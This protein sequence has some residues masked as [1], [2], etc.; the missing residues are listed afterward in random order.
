M[1]KKFLGPKEGTYLGNELTQY[2]AGVEHVTS[3]VNKQAL[4][5][6][7]GSQVATPGDRCTQLTGLYWTLAPWVGPIRNQRPLFCF[8]ALLGNVKTWQLGS[9]APRVV[10]KLETPEGPVQSVARPMGD[11]LVVG[12]I[13]NHWPLVFLTFLP[14][15]LQSHKTNNF[16]D[17]L[18]TLS[19]RYSRF[20]DDL[21]TC[22]RWDGH[23]PLV[24]TLPPYG[25]KFEQVF[26]S[27]FSYRG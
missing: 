27:L 9:Q 25:N 1:V 14:C 2:V 11:L 4:R 8:T 7:V 16:F 18:Q 17:F 20:P 23:W 19:D 3:G 24:F 13:R 10:G 12:P 22:R 5:Y 15:Y 21:D 26:F 6:L